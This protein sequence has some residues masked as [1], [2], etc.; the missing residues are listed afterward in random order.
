MPEQEKFKM[1]C[2]AK[3][4]LHALSMNREQKLDQ[5]WSNNKQESSNLLINKQKCSDKE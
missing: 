5:I 3:K 1:S 2:L 4:D